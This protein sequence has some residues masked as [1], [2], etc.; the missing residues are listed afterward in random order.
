MSQAYEPVGVWQ[1]LAPG[2]KSSLGVPPSACFW[3]SG[4][5]QLLSCLEYAVFIMVA[6]TQEERPNC[7]KNLNLYLYQF[8]E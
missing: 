4:Y 7:E 3:D 5:G 8:S 6:E 1:S 2:G